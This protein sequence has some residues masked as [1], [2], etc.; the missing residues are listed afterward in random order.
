M[1][2]RGEGDIK[3][4]R[5]ANSGGP[6]SWQPE[7]SGSGSGAM[8]LGA[9]LYQR[10]K[11]LILSWALI[12]GAFFIIAWFLPKEYTSQATVQVN[13]QNSMKFSLPE[14]LKMLDPKFNSGGS[15]TGVA[16]AILDS[17]KMAMN[18]IEAFS[19]KKKYRTK[20]DHLAIKQFHKNFAYE[21]FDEGIVQVSFT[22]SSQDTVKIILDSILGYLNSESIKYSTSKAK[23]E[24]DFNRNLVD[25]VYLH[26]DSLSRDWIRFM[27]RNKM[28][29]FEKNV[30]LSLRS[31]GQLEE[32]L[33]QLE[34]EYT[35]AKI[36]NSKSPQERQNIRAMIDMLRR[37]K[38]NLLAGRTP[39]K[40]E[41]GQGFE[42]AVNYDSIPSMAA[43]VEKLNLFV[44]KDKI[45]L[46]ALLPKLE[47]SR[48]KMVETTPVLN[49]LD[50]SYIPPYKSGPKRGFI[51]LLGTLLT[52]LAATIA[53]VLWEIL[54]NPSF[55]PKSVD[56]LLMHVRRYG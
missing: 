52:G 36:D 11:G 10:R 34:G 23:L 9:I 3:E 51:I 45:V 40:G 15:G 16:L 44:E 27:S 53:L 54:F 32:N 1:N 55:R 29:D 47:D 50:P 39:L 30:E 5:V 38:K 7:D 41:E 48:I 25:S 26:M 43:Y 37:K 31:Y 13:T 56:D 20:W 22:H 14:G 2:I 19:L 18:M 28:A 8:T 12:F 46:R 49:M 4:G 24:F 42:L 21:V 17:R 6:G 33:V 35:L